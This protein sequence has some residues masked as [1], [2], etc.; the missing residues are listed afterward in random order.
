LRPGEEHL[1]QNEGDDAMWGAG[2]DRSW[3]A[4]EDSIVMTARWPSTMER[5]QPL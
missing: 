4:E 3:R 2:I 1:L 5:R